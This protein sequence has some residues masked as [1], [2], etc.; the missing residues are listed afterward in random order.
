MLSLYS[1]A[2]YFDAIAA[3]FSFIQRLIASAAIA[4]SKYS[5]V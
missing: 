2:A 5:C 4:G 1:T 3:P